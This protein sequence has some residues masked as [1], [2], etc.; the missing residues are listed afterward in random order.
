MSSSNVYHESMNEFTPQSF[1]TVPPMPEYKQVSG[2]GL[3]IA[4]FV[5]VNRLIAAD[6]GH[7]LIQGVLFASQTI[8]YMRRE[9]DDV[10]FEPDPHGISPGLDELENDAKRKL[11]TIQAELV[12]RRSTRQRM[13]QGRM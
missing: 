5:Q 1:Q 7:G 11:Q 9:R 13:R 10:E 12:L 2:F 4:K 3:Q 6:I 8:G